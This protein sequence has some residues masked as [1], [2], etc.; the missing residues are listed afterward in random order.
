MN[1][2]RRITLRSSALRSSAQG[3]SLF[4]LIIVI[5]IVAVLMGFLL[6]RV[7]Y[8]QEQAEKT[9]MEGVL[10]TLESALVLQYGQ[11]LTRGKDSDVAALVQDNPMNWLQKKPRNYAGEFFEP[12]ASS[13][14]AGHWLFDLKSRELLYLP[15]NH[16]N[17]KPDKSGKPWIRFHV[18]SQAESSRL[19]SLQKAPPQLTGMLL[20]PVEPYAWF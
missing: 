13:A 12:L 9:A 19:P 16:D 2:I 15:R 5:S 17:L 6:N 20:Q 4:E 1:L 3:F 10:N 7:S 18:V 11:I 14:P 8:Y